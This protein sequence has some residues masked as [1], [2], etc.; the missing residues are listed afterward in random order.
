[1]KQTFVVASQSFE[2]DVSLLREIL[3]ELQAKTGHKEGYSFAEKGQLAAGW[4]FYEIY[5]K[6]EFMQKIIE[7]ESNEVKKKTEKDVLGIIQNWLKQKGSTA[8]IR[9]YKDKPIFARWWTWLMR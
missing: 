1:M 5:F 6:P 2:L 8:R 4:W 7:M 9:L 3:N